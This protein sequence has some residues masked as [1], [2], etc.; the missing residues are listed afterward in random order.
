MNAKSWLWPDRTIGKAESRN[1]REEHN[2]LVNAHV[3]AIQQLRELEHALAT[4]SELIGARMK[5]YHGMAELAVAKASK[6]S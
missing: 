6:E 4:G 3:E 5:Y 2:A 1:L